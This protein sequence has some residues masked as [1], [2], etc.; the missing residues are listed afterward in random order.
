MEPR[1]RTLNSA[2]FGAVGFNL[3]KSPKTQSK[4][5]GTPRTPNDLTRRQCWI[6]AVWCWFRAGPRRNDYLSTYQSYFDR[7]RGVRLFEDPS[8]YRRLICKANEGKRQDSMFTSGTA[9]TM[10]QETVWPL[11]KLGRICGAPP[12]T[13]HQL[14]NRAVGHRSSKGDGRKMSDARPTS[15]QSVVYQIPSHSTTHRICLAPRRAWR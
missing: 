15:Q 13:I 7:L 1:D 11:A 6:R 14:S 9:C 10:I 2:F 3:Q 5:S 4:G 8:T 12:H